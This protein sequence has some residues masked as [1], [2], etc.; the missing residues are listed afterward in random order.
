MYTVGFQHCTFNNGLSIQ[1]WHQ[2]ENIGLQRHSA[3]GLTTLHA[4]AAENSFF[5]HGH[6]T[7]SSIDYMLAHKKSLN[8]FMSE[9]LSSIFSTTMACT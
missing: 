1:T 2:Y 7:L 5:P 6:R 8:K 3:D 4:T 9:I